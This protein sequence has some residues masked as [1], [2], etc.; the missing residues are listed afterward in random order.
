MTSE[1]QWLNTAKVSC[2]LRVLVCWDH[3][4]ASAP[5]G[6]SGSRLIKG[7]VPTQSSQQGTGAVADC[8]ASRKPSARKG[9]ISS[10]HILLAV[11]SHMV[12]FNFILSRY[13]PI[14]CLKRGETEISGEQH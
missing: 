14:M 1:S 3:R 7:P 10:V 2:L 9:H 8:I 13:N 6:L 5:H 4:A 12:I 11:A